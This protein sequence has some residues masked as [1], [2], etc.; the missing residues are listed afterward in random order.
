[1]DSITV[2]KKVNEVIRNFQHGDKVKRVG[3]FG[4]V[5][6]GDSTDKSDIDLVVDFTYDD[7]L[8]SDPLFAIRKKYMFESVLRD[9][10][11]PV[12]VDIVDYSALSEES[13]RLLDDEI[14]EDVIWI[15]G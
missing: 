2:S 13:N 1:M 5:A 8:E 3:L 11:V 14:R 12:A 10:F 4:S 7:F 15:Y 9:A 6:R